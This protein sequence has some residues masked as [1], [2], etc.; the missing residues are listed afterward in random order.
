MEQIISHCGD[1]VPLFINGKPKVK[2]PKYVMWN[3]CPTCGEIFN[4]V[5]AFDYHRTGKYG[6]NRRCLTVKEMFKKGMIKNRFDRWIS[7]ASERDDIAEN[8]FSEQDK[9]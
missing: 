3:Q 2:I 8:D 1:G 9:G 5:Y 7:E 6:V 4:S